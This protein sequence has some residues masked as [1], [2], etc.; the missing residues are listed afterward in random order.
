MKV[1]FLLVFLCVALSGRAQHILIDTAA[2]VA[3]LEA[4]YDRDQKTRSGRDSAAFIAYIDS[5]NLAQVKHLID[6]YGWL[7]KSIVGARGNQALFL[8]IQ[9]ADLAIQEQYFPLL[10]QSVE[11]GESRPGHLALLNDRILMRQGKPQIYGSQVVFD[12]KGQAVFYPIEDEPNVNAR[13][14][15]MG[16]E[17][18]EQYAKHFGIEYHPP[19][20]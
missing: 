5:C 19:G 11:A 14:A 2:V 3:E 10:R 12:D 7:G 18:I 1:P 16:L 13:R 8:V 15:A 4:I 17:P 6:R 20:N 9:H